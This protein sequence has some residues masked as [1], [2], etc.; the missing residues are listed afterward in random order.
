MG[1]DKLFW[2][3]D[4]GEKLGRVCRCLSTKVTDLLLV[5]LVGIF[6]V[7][8]GTRTFGVNF[9]KD[10]VESTLGTDDIEGIYVVNGVEGM[11][12]T[13]DVTAILGVD[14]DEGMP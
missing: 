3:N 8:T 1:D 13:D 2:E 9:G 14:H 5:V 12:E 10:D 11:L 7:N 4:G 6:G